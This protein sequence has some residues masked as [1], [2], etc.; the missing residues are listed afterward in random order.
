MEGV[1][2]ACSALRSHGDLHIVGDART[3]A[4]TNGLVGI[5]RCPSHLGL[6]GGTHG[7]VD[8]IFIHLGVESL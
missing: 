3:L 5:I 7:E 4:D 1:G 6:L 2:T 8:G